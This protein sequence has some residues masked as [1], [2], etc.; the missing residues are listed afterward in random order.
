[1]QKRCPLYPQKRTLVGCGMSANR[2]SP[3]NSV[4]SAPLKLNDGANFAIEGDGHDY[5]L[6]TL[7]QRKSQKSQNNNS[8]TS[9]LFGSENLQKPNTTLYV[10]AP[11]LP[12][13]LALRSRCHVTRPSG[14]RIPDRRS[15][16][17]G[18][19]FVDVQQPGPVCGEAE[20]FFID[21]RGLGVFGATTKMSAQCR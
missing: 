9:C 3:L 15:P 12:T 21:Q 18:H 14:V 16:T 4:I 1:M 20:L 10:P 6:L 17:V 5:L 7:C 2:T 11:E 8:M 19:L 13:R